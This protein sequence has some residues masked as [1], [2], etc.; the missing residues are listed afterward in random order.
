LNAAPAAPTDAHYLSMAVLRQHEQWSEA[1]DGIK[2]SEERVRRVHAF[3]SSMT[4]SA[5]GC[6]VVPTGGDSVAVMCPASDRASGVTVAHGLVPVHTQA[7]VGAAH[8]PYRDTGSGLGRLR[9]H[10]YGCVTLR[11]TGEAES[12]SGDG[13]GIEVSL[14]DIPDLP[15]LLIFQALSKRR[16]H[17]ALAA[18]VCK[19]WYLMSRDPSLWRHVYLQRYA[20]RLRAWDTK[21]L[22]RTL[23]STQLRQLGLGGC[24]VTNSLFAQLSDKCSALQKLD[25]SFCNLA[26]VDP[27][28]FPPELTTIC[29]MHSRL[30]SA[31][32]KFMRRL[33]DRCPRLERLLLGGGP[34][35]RFTEPVLAELAV[36]FTNL[37]V[38]DVVQ[39]SHISSLAFGRLSVGFDHLNVLSVQGCFW[40]SEQELILVV[41][42]MPNLTQ[43]RVSGCPLMTLDSARRICREFKSRIEIVYSPVLCF[44]FPR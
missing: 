27:S 33:D 7:V 18:S 29:F 5:F 6:R 25:L 41:K 32:V 30:P 3:A 2:P 23:F 4:A 13:P 39:A 20:G 12:V 38:L 40:A 35:D 22:V 11:G 24:R 14:N 42:S 34:D 8:A 17:L 19:R 36:G 15:L 1:R 37:A 44:P 9:A 31:A 26:Q 43:L 28:N 21:R 10:G 16:S